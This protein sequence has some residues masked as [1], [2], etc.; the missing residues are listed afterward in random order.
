MPVIVFVVAMAVGTLAHDHWYA[1]GA[2]P[3]THALA[4]ANA[5]G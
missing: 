3:S 1:R 2:A 4:Q 5:D